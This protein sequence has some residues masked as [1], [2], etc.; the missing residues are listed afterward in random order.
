MACFS[1]SKKSNNFVNNK[2]IEKKSKSIVNYI[3][4]TITQNCLNDSMTIL[5][6]LLA[7][8]LQHEVDT[9]YAYAIQ[10]VS[11]NNDNLFQQFA[12]I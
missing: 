4:Y 3:A 8:L 6:I 9:Q 2:A 5:K 7:Y 10:T 12:R 1:Y 11:S